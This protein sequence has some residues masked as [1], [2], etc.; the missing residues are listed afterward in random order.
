MKNLLFLFTLII[1]SLFVNAQTV[2]NIQ[3]EQNGDII[4]ILYE[5]K[6]SDKNQVF[7]VTI[8]AKINEGQEIA[9]K[10]VTGTTKN[11]SIINKN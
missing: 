2:E 4:N 11:Y 7:K 10:S 5:I 9:L 1:A 6:N 8:T 3:V